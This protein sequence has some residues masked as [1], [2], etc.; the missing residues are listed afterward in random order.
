M[1]C[2]DAMNARTP[3]HRPGVLDIPEEARSLPGGGHCP[4]G[5]REAR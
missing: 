4:D 5:Q 1:L 2:H 3:N